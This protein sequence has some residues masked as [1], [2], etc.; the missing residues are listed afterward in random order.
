MEKRL[1]YILT[2]IILTAAE[3]LIALYVHDSFVRPYI[4]DVLVMGVLYCLIRSFLP[5]GAALL[6][7]WLFLMGVLAEL[8]QYFNLI[9]VLGLQDIAFMRILLGSTFDIK[10][11]ACYGTGC[12]LIILGEKAMKGRCRR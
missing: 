11:I 6:P 4:G 10:D 9:Y 1:V 8:L 12:L 3:V 5:N 2:F 7:L